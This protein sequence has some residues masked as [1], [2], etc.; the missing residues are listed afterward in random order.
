MSSVQSAGLAGG[1]ALHQSGTISRSPI[2]GDTV[3]SAST[4]SPT[5]AVSASGRE[6]EAVA[7]ALESA[8]RLMGEAVWSATKATSERPDI[9]EAVAG[10][11]ST[12]GI[13][14]VKVDKTATAQMLESP[15]FSG[16]GT[17]VG[18][19]TLNLDIGTWGG[20]D[21]AFV[22]NPNWPKAAVWTGPKDTSLERVRDRINA[23]GVGVSAMVVSD[24]SGS[25][26]ILRASATGGANGFKVT[27][28]PDPQSPDIPNSARI[29]LS[30][31]AYSDPQSGQGMKL[32]QAGSDA[33]LQINGRSVTTN[34]NVVHDDLSDITFR[35]HKPDA[36][37]I[38]IRVEPD[39][40]AA[41]KATAS[42]LGAVNHLTRISS[43]HE[44]PLDAES[45]RESV[46]PPRQGLIRPI[47]ESL[48]EI[49]VTQRTDGILELDAQRLRDR[50]EQSPDAVNRLLA[51]PG[52]LAAR[53]AA[54]LSQASQSLPRIRDTPPSP[55]P[56]ESQPDPALSQAARLRLLDAYQTSE[57]AQYG[58]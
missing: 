23:A 1:I 13:Y 32:L 2:E 55:T 33:M 8:M 12:P 5:V 3:T 39:R 4:R 10:A 41:V 16:L 22:T 54:D 42:L 21:S 18:L 45:P 44:S 29:E 28:T 20:S 37:V 52:G 34:S 48:N 17:T 57:S 40:E 46:A 50:M 35:V 11:R 56:A 30:E 47:A 38:S 25:R 43:D 7:A 31:L 14:L 15:V 58:D 36:D 51:G 19:G 53:L 49:G 24:A 26:L 6:H 9:V 27:A